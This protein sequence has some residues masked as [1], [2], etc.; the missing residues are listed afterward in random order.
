MGLCLGSAIVWLE[1]TGPSHAATGVNLAPHRVHTSSLFGTE[2][3]Y[4]AQM[5]EIRKNAQQIHTRLWFGKP[6]AC[7][8]GHG[9]NR[10]EQMYFKKKWQR[11]SWDY[12]YWLRIGARVR[13]DFNSKEKQTSDFSQP[14]NT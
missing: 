7:Q 6:H 14:P 9:Y 2:N 5:E 3:R 10:M 13:G 12:T 11:A 4:T 8:Q 1:W